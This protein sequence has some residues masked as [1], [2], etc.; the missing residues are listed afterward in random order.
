MPSLFQANAWSTIARLTA[1]EET[2]FDPFCTAVVSCAIRT[3]R[4]DEK[5][6]SALEAPEICMLSCARRNCHTRR[7]ENS[8]QQ[9]RYRLSGVARTRY[10]RIQL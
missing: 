3:A 4:S 7:G 9:R 5:L 8:G 2:W 6:L 10:R 1:E